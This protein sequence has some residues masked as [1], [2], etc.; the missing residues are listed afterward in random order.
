M[1][2]KGKY[3]YGIAR[4]AVVGVSAVSSGTETEVPIWAAPCRCKVMR[5]G[6][7]PKSAITGADTNYMTLSFK[8]K[9]SDGTGTAVIASK[10]FTNGVNGAAFDYV[11]FG[12]VSNNLLNE[13]DVV[14]FAKA[15]SGSGMNMP[16]LVA[17]IEYVRR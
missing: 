1:A 2:K 3:F 7:I 8:N 13:G 17:V 4:T 11:T 16:D 15:E 9:G 10:A 14:S 5:V 6:I 12:A